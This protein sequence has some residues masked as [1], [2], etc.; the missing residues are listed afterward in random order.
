MSR[1]EK[2]QICTISFKAEAESWNVGMVAAY[3]TA[4]KLAPGLDL[5][6]KVCMV[7]YSSFVSERVHTEFYIYGPLV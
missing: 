6:W 5:T 1:P 7:L 4:Q 2:P 3:A